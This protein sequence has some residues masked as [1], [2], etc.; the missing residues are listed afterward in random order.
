[1]SPLC[2]WVARKWSVDKVDLLSNQTM[3]TCICIGISDKPIAFSSEAMSLKGLA[4][5]YM[6]IR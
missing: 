3:S 2:C 5:L 1:M 6:T 4:N